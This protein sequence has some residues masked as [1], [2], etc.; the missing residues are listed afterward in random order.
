MGTI[1]DIG[2]DALIAR[3]VEKMPREF[4]IEAGPGDDCAVVDCGWEDAFQLLKTDAL[5]GRVHYEMD[6]APEAVGWKAIARVVSDFAAMGGQAERFLVTLALPP[7]TEV[8][9]VEGLYAGMGRCLETYGAVLSGGETSSVPSGSVPVISIAAT[10]RVRRD[11]VVLRSTGRVGDRL[12]VTGCLGGSLAGR[13]LSF[14]PRVTEAA[15]LV[16]RHKPTAMMDVSDGLA[17]DLPRLAEASG[18]G[19]RLERDS[20]P[21]AAGCSMDQA[22][23]DG[24]D[25]ELLFAVAEEEVLV[26]KASWPLEFP[27]VL[28]SEIG[29]LVAKGEGD[30]LAGGWDHFP[31]VDKKDQA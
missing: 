23:G 31:M 24:E 7:E 25:F 6:A 15:W 16:K 12:F 19:Y 5:V 22:L 8:A 1:R 21:C 4:A 3:L 26:L 11:E 30:Q 18:C 13:H 28:L 2:E 29:Y 9:W 27:N 20:L 17:K 10:G 14:E